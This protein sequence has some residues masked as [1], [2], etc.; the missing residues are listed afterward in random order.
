MEI[1]DFVKLDNLSKRELSKRELSDIYGG[2]NPCCICGCHGTNASDGGSS[3]S[4]ATDEVDEGGGTGAGAFS[5]E[6]G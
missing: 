5:G 1:S 4:L 6:K 3:H 2:S